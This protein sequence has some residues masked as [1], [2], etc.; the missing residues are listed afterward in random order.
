[1]TFERVIENLDGSESE[2]LSFEAPSQ[3]HAAE[4]CVGLFRDDP[5]ALRVRLYDAERLICVL[6]NP[7]Y[8]PG[9]RS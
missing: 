7:W 2:R 8:L 4:D 6:P 9:G 3:G 5:E 1:M